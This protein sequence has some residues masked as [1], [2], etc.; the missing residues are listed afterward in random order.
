MLAGV[1]ELADREFSALASETDAYAADVGKRTTEGDLNIEINTTSLLEYLP[2][3]VEKSS[4]RV[5]DLVRNSEEYINGP[6]IIAELKRFGL[7]TLKDLSDILTEKV[8]DIYEKFTYE[9]SYLG[10]LRD[11]MMFADL[12]LYFSKAW[13]GN[14]NFIDEPTINFLNEKYSSDEIENTLKQYGVDLGADLYEDFR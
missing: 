11:M 1:L 3:K 4:K 14:W 9:T 10:L 13:K 2:K 6:D 5:F 7:S 8:F 12:T